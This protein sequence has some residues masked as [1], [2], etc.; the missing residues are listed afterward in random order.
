MFNGALE[1]YGVSH[2]IAYG[3]Y[4]A[5]APLMIVGLVAAAWS[6]AREEWR[7]FGATLAVDALDLAD[8]CIGAWRSFF[9]Q[10]GIVEP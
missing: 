5:T 1:A 8:Q 10:H 9:T 3:I 6:G 4:P 7:T 2:A